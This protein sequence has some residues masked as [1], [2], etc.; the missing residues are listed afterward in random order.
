MLQLVL[1]LVCGLKLISALKY[2]SL[3]IF[4]FSLCKIVLTLTI[5]TVTAS[6]L[7]YLLFVLD[8]VWPA[9]TYANQVK[10]ASLSRNTLV[11]SVCSFAFIV[12]TLPLIAFQ[13]S[14]L[15]SYR[16]N[17]LKMARQEYMHHLS[18]KSNRT[19]QDGKY[20]QEEKHLRYS[21]SG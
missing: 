6:L 18:L 3:H 16:N 5:G 9:Q 8:R 12:L 1:L 17:A 2:F 14:L 10:M 4:E 15:I 21:G 13:L 11:Y 19:T 7:Y 20:C